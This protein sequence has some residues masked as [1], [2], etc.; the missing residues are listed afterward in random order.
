MWCRL[1]SR[2]RVGSFPS[3]RKHESAAPS[4]A[5]ALI[6]TPVHHPA[7]IDPA[8]AI[9]AR[10]PLGLDMPAKLLLRPAR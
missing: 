7:K 1:L 6:K 5:V 2:E 3:N 9:V 10:E 4:L 8:L